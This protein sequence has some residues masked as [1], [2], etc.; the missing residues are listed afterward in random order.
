MI[1]IKKGSFL[2]TV[3]PEALQ[4]AKALIKELLDNKF[5]FRI[6]TNSYQKYPSKDALKSN[7]SM[8]RSKLMEEAMKKAYT[9]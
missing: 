7:K 6:Q 4:I 9:T 8:N 5:H 3:S 2:S 1:R